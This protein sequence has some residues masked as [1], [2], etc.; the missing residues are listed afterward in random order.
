MNMFCL[1]K[2]LCLRPN[3]KRA[4]LHD[5]YTTWLLVYSLPA[6]A[7]GVIFS[8][9]GKLQGEILFEAIIK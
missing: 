6:G 9:F 2:N 4:C 3:D 7:V 8:G 5:K 1:S